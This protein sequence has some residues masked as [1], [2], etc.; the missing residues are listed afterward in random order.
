MQRRCADLFVGCARTQ[1]GSFGSTLEQN[2]LGER[3][4]NGQSEVFA[5]VVDRLRRIIITTNTKCRRFGVG[6]RSMD[7]DG[8]KIRRLQI[9]TG[10]GVYE[11]CS[12]MPVRSVP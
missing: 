7:V 6:E 3:S 1:I 5:N 10:S 12:A 8:V 4:L 9:E 11:T 2:R